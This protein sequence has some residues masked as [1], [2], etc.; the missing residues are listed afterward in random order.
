[1]QSPSGIKH[2]LNSTTVKV[3]FMTESNSWVSLSNDSSI[4]FEFKIERENTKSDQSIYSSLKSALKIID[5]TLTCIDKASFGSPFF[6]FSRYNIKSVNVKL[7][8]TSIAIYQIE[9][10][11][12]KYPIVSVI[13]PTFTGPLAASSKC[14]DNSFVVKSIKIGWLSC[15]FV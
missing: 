10:Y 8:A 2:L 12:I 6:E 14:C 4:E 13:W 15:P 11:L 3:S 9:E 5:W 1:M 7:L